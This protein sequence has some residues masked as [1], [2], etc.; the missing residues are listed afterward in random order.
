M[1]R[2][3]KKTKTPKRRSPSASPAASR[4]GRFSLISL[5]C[6]KALV[7]S[8]RMAGSLA[9]AGFE[10]VAEGEPADG[11]L[12]NTCGFLADARAESEAAIDDALRLKREGRVGRVVV[13]GCLVNHQG[14]AL[15][16]RF[17][18][19]D[20]FLPLA[21][22]RQVVATL[23]GGTPRAEGKTSVATIQEGEAPAEPS[24]PEPSR[25]ETPLAHDG[26]HGAATPRLRLTLPHVAYLKIA[27]GCNRL[28]SFCAIPAIR[29]RYVSRPMGEIEVEARALVESGVRELVIIAQDTSYYGVDRDG[30]PQLAE[31]LRRLE[32]IDGLAWIRLMYLYPAHLTDELLDVIAG[33]GRVLPY[34]D[35]PLQHIDDQ[36]LQRMRRQVSRRT[37]EELL[38]RLRQRIPNLTLR[39][40]MIVGFPGETEQQFAE[41][42]E[43]VRRQRFERL[44]AFAYSDEPGTAAHQLEGKL[45]DGTIRQ[46]LDALL[47]LQAGIAADWGRQQVGARRRV[48]IDAPLAEQ[49]GVYLARSAADAPEVD[50]TVYLTAEEGPLQ[51]GDFVECEVVASQ[52]Y[53]LIAVV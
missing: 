19:V 40:T 13:A 11:I 23:E 4:G 22:E 34:M 41:L 37:T 6:P 20:C 9:E 39:T 32:T 51:P 1:A 15:T 42:T 18:E 28:C 3:R 12:V 27:E 30:R 21:D 31:L 43:F 45:P 36:M 26:A 5:G 16:E 46:R 2:R 29:G 14:T 10:L 24:R 35:L 38:D 44:G 49:P 25:P 52:G 47:A 53:D 48:I 17:P 7:D 50:G 33:S 8:E